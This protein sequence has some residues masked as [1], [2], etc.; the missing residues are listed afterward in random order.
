MEHY[1]R[2]QALPADPV[3]LSVSE[4]IGSM[5]RSSVRTL[6]GSTADHLPT[7]IVPA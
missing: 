6:L 1:Q 2:K 7:D 3:L 5:W 4:T